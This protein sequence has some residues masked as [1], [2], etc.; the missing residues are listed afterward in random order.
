MVL[1]TAIAALYQNVCC[2]ERGAHV[3]SGCTM[4]LVSSTVSRRSCACKIA[5]SSSISGW[6][7]ASCLAVLAWQHAML[8]AMKRQFA[9]SYLYVFLSLSVWKGPY[10]N[11]LYPL[12]FH[13]PP[14]TLV[15]PPPPLLWAPSL[16]KTLQSLAHCLHSCL[17][18]FYKFKHL[19]KSFKWI[20][21]FLSFSLPD[22]QT[23]FTEWDWR[24]LR[25][26]LLFFFSSLCLR[27]PLHNVLT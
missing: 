26:S 19:S 15:T 16:H 17:F 6:A 22:T 8:D 20:S 9:S 25:T 23:H 5:D 2:C 24:W 21:F 27:K 13:F 18:L 1:T 10:T 7:L 12:Q 3:S 14:L 11:V 4:S